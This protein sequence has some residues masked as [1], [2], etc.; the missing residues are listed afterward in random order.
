MWGIGAHACN[1]SSWRQG[2]EAL[3]L[4]ASLSHIGSYSKTKLGVQPNGT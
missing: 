3:N 4:M 1:L 2:Q